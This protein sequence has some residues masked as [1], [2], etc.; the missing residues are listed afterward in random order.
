MH[1]DEAYK[2]WMQLEEKLKN[3]GSPDEASGLKRECKNAR[4]N[5]NAVAKHFGYPEDV[6]PDFAFDRIGTHPLENFNGNVRDTAHSND[7]MSST[8]HIIARAHVQKLLKNELNIPNVRKKRIN[9]GGVRVSHSK[10]CIGLPASEIN[11]V[12]LVDSLFAMSDAAT[13]E[14]ILN[15][16]Y[17]NESI[18]V[19]VHY[20]QECERISDEQDCNPKFTIPDEFRNAG[21]GDRNVMYNAK[22][23]LE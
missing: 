20:L 18:N 19:F 23:D 3:A 8:S 4:S 10:N 6:K 21:I 12:V 7:I 2:E 1:V 13:E 16:E 5:F 17:S 15:F 11:P 14:T 22:K 9:A